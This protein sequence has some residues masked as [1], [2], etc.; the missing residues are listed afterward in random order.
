[1]V[2]S[3]KIKSQYCHNKGWC[4]FYFFWIYIY[5]WVVSACC[6]SICLQY[7]HTAGS[8]QIFWWIY[9]YIWV[10]LVYF[11][12]R[13]KFC[14]IQVLLRFF[15]FKFGFKLV[16]NLTHPE[17]STLFLKCLDLQLQNRQLKNQVV[18]VFFYI[19]LFFSWN[20]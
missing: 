13:F 2:S 11:F 8:W 1:M 19:S 7:C 15:R 16:H 20:L 10:V 9:I 18:S 14:I 3:L 12:W 4:Q 17:I 5:F 6:Y